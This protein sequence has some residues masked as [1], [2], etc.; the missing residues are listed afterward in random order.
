MTPYQRTIVALA[1]VAVL[2]TAWMSR[3]SIVSGA[4]MPFVLDRWT[5]KVH[6][7]TLTEPN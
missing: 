4:R 3:Y 1:V 6:I 7:P 5:G 2:L